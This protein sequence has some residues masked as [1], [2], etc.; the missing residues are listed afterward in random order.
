MSSR[1]GTRPAW[2]DEPGS[3]YRRPALP[4]T[5]HPPVV[6]DTGQPAVVA[7][8]GQ[9][10]AVPD[11]GVD[12]QPARGLERL[13][14][15]RGW[16]VAVI[17][18]IQA[19]LSIRLVWSTTAFIDEGEYLTVGH[20]ELAHFLHHAVM[21][22]VA[23]YL[24]GSPLVYP[25]L[26]AVADN[27]GGLAAA[28]LLSL[29][30]MLI[31][32]VLLHGVARRLLAS[33]TVAFF[34]AAL[35]GWLGTTQFL[36]AF[37][38]YD[39][40]ALMLLA[41][42][43]WLGVRALEASPALR[44]TL[45]CAGG[46]SMA[47]ADAAKYAAALFNPVVIAVVALAA[48]KE[49]GRKGG[50]DTAGALVL[51]AAVPL[52]VGYD[53]SGSSLGKGI[54]STTLTR[55][56]GTDSV[57]TVL[58]LSAH[59]AGIVAVLAVLGAVLIT[60]RRPGW[61]TVALAWTL[62]G[63]AFLAPAEQARIH[64]ITSLFKHVGYGAWFACVIAGYLLAEFSALWARRGRARTDAVPGAGSRPGLRWALA[65]S[66]AVVLLAGA[67]GVTVANG[68]YRSWANSRVMLADLT[69]LLPPGGRNFYLFED[70]SVITYYLRSKIPFADIDSTYTNTFFYTDPQTHQALENLPA[71][72]DAIKRGYFTT[73]VL[74]F[75]DTAGIDESIAQDIS[76]GRNYRLVDVIPYRTSFGPSTY[77]IW[78]RIPPRIAHRI[79]HRT[80]HRKHRR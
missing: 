20:L 52:T 50:L 67:Y 31:A 32:T 73:I 63:A 80:A 21:P 6:A 30:F 64:T 70:P 29:A 75:G 55:T 56:V 78:Q 53:V 38:T 71:Y 68:Q 45:V 72:A 54:T 47:V 17:L 23:T 1:P 58:A 34:A 26:V 62:A 25:P 15:V 16:P 39:P 48:W 42:A 61:P 4:D 10:P 41:L 79:P 37:A 18:A 65:V 40:M 12:V 76:T 2:H 7:H 43:T 9:P 33:R 14:N 46:L 49:H 60:V 13:L 28:R 74:S 11:A 5:G 51:A 59:A 66:T 22:D 19:A 44:Y 57:H 35:F 36:G 8:S 3:L 77:K 24:S 69:R 27:I